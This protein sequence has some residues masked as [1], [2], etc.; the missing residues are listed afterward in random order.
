M[1][2]RFIKAGIKSG[3]KL[4]SEDLRWET[5]GSEGLKTVL[6]ELAHEGWDIRFLEDF[7]SHYE[8]CQETGMS[9]VKSKPYRGSATIPY[10]PVETTLTIFENALT[11]KPTLICDVSKA[12][13]S[14]TG[15]PFWDGY[16]RTG[17]LL[18]TRLVLAS[19]FLNLDDDSAVKA[20]NDDIAR[21][22]ELI[23]AA[24]S[25][26]NGCRTEFLPMNGF[27]TPHQ[28]LPL[29][30][31]ITRGYARIKA[32]ES[33]PIKIDWDKTYGLILGFD[34]YMSRE[35]IKVF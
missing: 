34:A 4:Q 18:I 8:W 31:A 22:R 19:N 25:S 27:S 15:V 2:F 14:S 28:S 5:T 33:T 35:G 16:A 26:I 20:F 21:R 7:F 17:D 13:T 11:G 12:V 32:E 10:L 29:H 23:T 24:N 3:L 30:Q 9:Q 6:N 1:V